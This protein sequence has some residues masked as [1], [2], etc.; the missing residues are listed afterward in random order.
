MKKSRSQEVNLDERKECQTRLRQITC[1]WARQGFR[2]P[3]LLNLGLGNLLAFGF[4]D[5]SYGLMIKIQE[6]D[7]SL[8]ES[9]AEKYAAFQ[10]KTG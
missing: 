9:T 3:T 6:L 2:L 1:F 10:D 7:K 5:Y 8:I 4:A